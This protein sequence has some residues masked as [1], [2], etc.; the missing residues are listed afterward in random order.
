MTA[1]P[2][3][4]RVRCKNKGCAERVPL[5]AEQVRQLSGTLRARLT[6]PRCQTEFVTSLVPEVKRRTEPSADTPLRPAPPP[7][8]VPVGAN[9]AQPPFRPLTAMPEPPAPSP[10]TFPTVPAVVSL[11]LPV[12]CP[13]SPIQAGAGAPAKTD[14]LV[15]RWNRLPKRTQNLVLVAGVAVAGVFAAGVKFRGQFLPTRQPT[16]EVAPATPPV[17]APD[18]PTEAAAEDAATER[19]ADNPFNPSPRR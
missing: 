15:G 6:C 12:D 2:M 18:E 5:T 11:P 16:P 1:V 17:A 7:I 8:P 14:G 9:L 3:S 13:F 19:P 10:A 4:A